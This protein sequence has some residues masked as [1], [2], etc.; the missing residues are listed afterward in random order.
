VTARIKQDDTVL[1]THGKDK[2][3]RGK[4][5]RIFPAK[6][7]VL[8]EGLNIAKRHLRAGA[9]G[10]RQAGIVSQEM[11]LNASKVM[12]ICPSCDKPT[13]IA[14]QTLEDGAKARVCKRCNAMMT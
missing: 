13:R 9:Q 10:A 8:V 5:Q 2:G 11:P 14:I 6:N 12:P 1:V 3:R 4:V 7:K